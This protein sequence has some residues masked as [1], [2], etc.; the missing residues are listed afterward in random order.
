MSKVS[1][2]MKKNKISVIV[3]VYNVEKY[4]EKCL[5]S[6]INQTYDNLE[7]IVVND[8]ST[9]N[10][11][12][13]I[14]KYELK[15]NK[16]K[17]I[18]NEENR[19]LSFSR[20]A[21]LKV[22]TG[23]YIGYID[24]DDYVPNN[25][26]ECLIRSIESAGAEIAVCDINV[27]YE[28]SNTSNRC[29]CGTYDN[30]KIDFVNNGLAASACNKLFKKT[31][32]E[33]YMFE[34]GKIN[35]DIAVIIPLIVKANKVVYCADVFYNYIQRKNSIQNSSISDKRFDIF[36]GVEQTLERIKGCKNYSE[37]EMA[38]VFQQI[39]MLFIYVLPKESSFFKRRNLFKKFNILSR[40]YCIRKNRYFWN[41]LSAQ[42][43]KHRLYYK[44]LFK[45]NCNG[46]YFT[47]SLMVEAYKLLKKYFFTSVI[48][49]N[50]TIDDLIKKAKYQKKLSYGNV[51]ISVVIPNYN[52]EKF[53]FQR[54]YSILYQNVKID[55]I[56]I[57]DDCSK[58]KSRELIEFI[59]EKLSP[60]ID[61]KKNFNVQNSGSAFKQWEKGMNLAKSEYV[62]IAEADDYCSDKMLK[63]LVR[64]LEKNK[65]IVLSY[66]D[67]AFMDKDGFVF[68]KSIIPEI[69]I[70]KTGHWNK[71]YI[72]DGNDEFENYTFLNCTIANVSSC[73]I[74][75]QDYSFEFKLCGQYKQ[76]GDW[77]FYA[78]IMHKGMISFYN[79][80]LNYYRVHGNNVSSVTKKQD[81]LNE[82]VRIHNYYDDVYKLTKF[83]KNEINKRYK[84]LRKVWGLQDNDKKNTRK[85]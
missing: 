21:G 44:L 31:T 68:M 75:K 42:G 28:D 51:S 39:I 2:L 35:E 14:K 73:V 79:E 23:S 37:Y 30:N 17:Y 56:I 16:I 77:L 5:D 74:K 55:E 80:P 47:S 52:Y 48:K 85:K 81:H 32:I 54:L 62:W 60:Y 8:C 45:F 18:K 27:V 65:N 53:L 4:L 50:I 22:A 66:C 84:F 36:Y 59:V 82:L 20:N 67:T 24:S 29:Q 26:Y 71:S 25:Y 12:E 43:T 83:Q 9:D 76:A 11:E 41:F 49:K 69:D 63:K 70:M 7:I 1:D 72:N 57:L 40:K 13:I 64:P 38:I 58:D 6:L 46:F 33:Q 34:E 15:S 3:P 61:I 19:G 10:S 78:S